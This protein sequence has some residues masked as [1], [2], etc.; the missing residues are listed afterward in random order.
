MEKTRSE[1][2][3]RNSSVSFIT[4]FV[5]IFFRFGLQTVFIRI[6]GEAYLSIN[7]LFTQILTLLSI[8][9]LGV[10][11]A[12]VFNLYKPLAI[13][14]EKHIAALLSFYRKAYMVIG[15][16]IAILGLLLLPFLNYLTQGN[17]VP[18][19]HF[20]FLLFLFNSVI[21]YFYSYKA[22]IL[23][24]SQRDYV[25]QMYTVFVIMIQTAIQA[26][27]L[28]TTGNYIAF[29]VAQIIGT[30]TTNL[31]IA[32]KVEKE[33][34]YLKE[35][36][37]EK[38]SQ[39][40]FKLIKRNVFEL[41]GS[42]VGSVVIQG[43]DAVLVSALGYLSQIGLFANYNLIISNISIL[44]SRIINGSIASI[45]NLAAEGKPDEAIVVFKNHFFV[46]FM[47]TIFCGSMLL[48]LL[49]PFVTIWAGPDFLFPMVTVTILVL[50]YYLNQI[51]QTAIS[52]NLAYGALE[53]QGVKS[54]IEAVFNIG[55]SYVLIVT[56]GL[57]MGAALLGTILTNLLINSWF[58]S[59]QIFRLGFKRSVKKF[60]VYQYVFYILGAL[61]MGASYFLVNLIQTNHTILNLALYT[62][63]TPVILICLTTLLFFR[64]PEYKNMLRLGMR[65]I[66][67]G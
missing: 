3:L 16:S 7:G 29:L 46:N 45:G 34:P 38:I 39:T 59:F 62:I 11:S 56:T 12:I 40:E 36:R 57:G 67:R 41:M 18:H 4:Q 9:E 63:A 8:C 42:K 33:Y 20:I 21:S 22:T 10:G 27:I 15:F 47:I 17:T 48:N 6:L 31:L 14:D 52:F 26:V 61:I 43:S 53:Y 51:R 50:N 2:V 65:F 28:L 23:T 5:T 35:Y 13:K 1:N 49:N 25:I 24:A 58:D 30:I 66:K 55:I 32:R 60:W 54:V 37:E 44:Q 19:I 64:L